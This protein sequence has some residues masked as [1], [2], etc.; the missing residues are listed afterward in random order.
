MPVANGENRKPSSLEE[1]ER[2][3]ERRDDLVTER[4]RQGPTR[5]KVILNVCHEKGIGLF[6][7]S[8]IRPPS[9]IF[10]PGLQ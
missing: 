9:R 1:L 8:E 6:Q 3:M 5:Q 4:N 2:F 10:S 7:H